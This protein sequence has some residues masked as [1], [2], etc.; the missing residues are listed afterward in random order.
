MVSIRNIKTIAFLKNKT[1][2]PK[3]KRKQTNKTTTT[4]PGYF[5]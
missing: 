2:T 3:Q 4:K 5:Y 1:K